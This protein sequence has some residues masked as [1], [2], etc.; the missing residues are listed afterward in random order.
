[1][2]GSFRGTSKLINQATEEMAQN[3]GRLRESEQRRLAIA[4]QF[5]GSVKKVVSAFSASAEQVKHTAAQLYEAAG[6][7]AEW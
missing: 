5:E 6:E 4:D 7:S 1:M 3:A 2:L